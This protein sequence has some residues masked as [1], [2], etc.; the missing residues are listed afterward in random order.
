M[1]IIF[2]LL[3][4]LAIGFIYRPKEKIALSPEVIEAQLKLLDH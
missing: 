4:Y 2:F 3:S 1:G